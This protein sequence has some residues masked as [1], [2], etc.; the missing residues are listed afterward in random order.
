MK[1]LAR[2]VWSQPSDAD[3][4]GLAVSLAVPRHQPGEVAKMNFQYQEVR[5]KAHK[6]FA[7]GMKQDQSESWVGASDKSVIFRGLARVQPG[8]QQCFLP[9]TTHNPSPTQHLSYQR[10]TSS[11]SHLPVYCRNYH[12]CHQNFSFPNEIASERCVKS[13]RPTFLCSTARGYPN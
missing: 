10:M 13:V 1:R 4:P 7:G 3:G 9:P 12:R 6:K 11:M 5:M 2:K 8:W